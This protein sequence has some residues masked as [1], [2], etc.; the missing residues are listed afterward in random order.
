MLLARVVGHVV[1]TAHHPGLDAATMLLVRPED[2]A[3]APAGPEMTAL[4]SVGA[5]VGER[6]LV[7]V[8]GR[9]ASEA[10]RRAHSPVDAAV[11]GIVDT[12]ELLPG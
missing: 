5:G 10:T 1:A 2:P 4:D 9:S 6:V 3:G 7:V 8:E 11:V 12:L